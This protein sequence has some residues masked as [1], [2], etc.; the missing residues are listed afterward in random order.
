[1]LLKKES[2]HICRGFK[3]GYIFVNRGTLKGEN[4]LKAGEK[5]LVREELRRES[6]AGQ[7]FWGR[8]SFRGRV[9]LFLCRADALGGKSARGRGF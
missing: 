2:L 6:F 1:M 9:F 5:V 8:K 4:A 3:G 7:R